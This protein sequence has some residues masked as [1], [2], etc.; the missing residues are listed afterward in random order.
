MLVPQGRRIFPNL[1]VQENL[2]I[3]VMQAGRNGHPVVWTPDRAYELLPQL[4]RLCARPGD[5]MSGGELQMLA[6]ARA[7]MSNGRLLMLDEPFEEL[8]ATIVEG[9][10][11]VINELK[12]EMTILLVEQNADLALSLGD[13][14]YVVNN[15]QFEALR[16][17]LLGV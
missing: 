3:A 4:G 1:T 16:Q 7:L 5:Q 14:V 17:K 9:L 10:W 8:A 2:E 6:I 15:G 13:R 12:K 11:K